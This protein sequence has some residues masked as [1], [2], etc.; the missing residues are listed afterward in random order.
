VFIDQLINV[1]GLIFLQLD[2]SRFDFTKEQFRAT[3]LNV[4]VKGPFK[5]N[6]TD[7]SNLYGIKEQE[8]LK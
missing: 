3:Y 7:S 4:D 2:Y 1:Y 8:P 6:I 5:N